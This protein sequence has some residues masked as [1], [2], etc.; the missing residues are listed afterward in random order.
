MCVQFGWNLLSSFS[1]MV[2]KW[3]EVV[4]FTVMSEQ[5]V[6]RSTVTPKG[7]S[8]VCEDHSGAVWFKWCGRSA[9]E[10]NS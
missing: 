6:G 8:R 3:K 1:D 2:R 7:T 4:L 10:T 5:K 9:P